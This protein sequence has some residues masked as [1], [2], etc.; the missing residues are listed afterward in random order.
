MK[1]RRL[2]CRRNGTTPAPA[3]DCIRTC[4]QWVADRQFSQ[5]Q[6]QRYSRHFLLPE[7]GEEGQAKLL[8][9]KVLCI[10]AGAFLAGSGIEQTLFD[11]SL[12]AWLT[13]QMGVEYD[14]RNCM[15][16]GMALGALQFELLWR[17]NPLPAAHR[18]WTTWLVSH[19]L[20]IAWIHALHCRF[21]FRDAGRGRYWCTL[22]GA[23]RAYTASVRR[24]GL[25]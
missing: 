21:T 18:S 7:V 6:I 22:G 17:L 8:D 4:N 10:G 2:S 20:G 14:P 9:A 3:D 5:D 1:A 16:V 11:G 13:E 12:R 15:V 24:Y 25:F 19:G 23:Y